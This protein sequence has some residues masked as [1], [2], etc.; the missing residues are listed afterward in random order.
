MRN[1]GCRYWGAV[2]KSVVPM[3]HRE[4][5][6]EV[7]KVCRSTCAADHGVG[8]CRCW[9]PEWWSEKWKERATLNFK[10]CM[11]DRVRSGEAG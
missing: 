1:V 10:S 5:E 7:V 6:V 2:R 4:A 3:R 9:V 8:R 11:G